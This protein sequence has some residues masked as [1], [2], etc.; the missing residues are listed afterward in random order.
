MNK[1]ATAATLLAAALAWAPPVHAQDFPS[2]PVKI[3]VPY[4]AGGGTDIVARILAQKLQD[5]WGGAPVIVENRAGA[6]GNLGAEVVFTA[7]PDGYTLL[8]T[9]QGPLVVNQSLYE[10]LNYD[11]EKFTPVSLVMVAYSALLANPKVPAESVQQLIAYAKANPDK[12]NYASQGI[13]TAAHLT[14][15]LFKSMAGVKI[16]HIPYRGSGPALNDLV[17]G[18]VDIMFGELAPAYPHVNAGKLRALAVSGDKRIAG[19]PNVPTVAEVLP[20]F[21]VTSWWAVVAPPQTPPAIADKISAAIAAVTQESEVSKR[22]TDMSM[23]PTGSTPADLSKFIK[24]EAERWGNVIRT[25]GAKA[26]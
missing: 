18:H 6:G 23:V 3:V 22:L 24:D 17:A 10:K 15:E 5:K 13:G 8:F 1:I 14:A 20:G 12:L 9:A 4:A 2:K 26:Q 16:N 25:S 7:A 19:L 21:V 11:P